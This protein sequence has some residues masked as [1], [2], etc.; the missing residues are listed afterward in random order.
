MSV[1][2]ILAVV[3]DIHSSAG[4]STNCPLNSKSLS[5]WVKDKLPEYTYV[6]P[7]SYRR[8]ACVWSA[9]CGAREFEI[10]FAGRWDGSS[11]HFSSYMEEGMNMYNLSLDNND[12]DPIRKFWVWR[13]CNF[14]LT[15]ETKK[16]SKKIFD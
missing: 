12:L 15:L 5:D 7:Y 8:S 14:G 3:R 9:R 2:P 13:A 16:N 1:S 6:T 10:R 11:R 4:E